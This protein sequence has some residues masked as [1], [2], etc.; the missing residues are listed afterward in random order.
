MT[1]LGEQINKGQ[2]TYSTRC[3]A[4][5]HLFLDFLLLIPPLSC[6][7]ITSFPNNRVILFKSLFHSDCVT[8]MTTDQHL[9]VYDK[10]KTLLSRGCSVSGEQKV[11]PEP[12]RNYFHLMGS[13]KAQ[14]F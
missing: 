6:H 1:G 10:N 8:A 7:S 12:A 3:Q 11:E 5:L 2:F 4:F 13:W 9:H 14:K